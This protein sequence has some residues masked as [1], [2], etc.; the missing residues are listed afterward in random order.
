M[1][2][3]FNKR[4]QKICKEKNNRLCIGLD[5]D[6]NHFPHFRNKT[7]EAMEAFAKDVIDRTID[8]CPVYK[9]NFA[10]YERYGSKGYA[11]LER[12]VNFI[13]NRSLV[14]ADAKRGDIGNTSYQYSKSILDNMGCDAITVS[15]YM[16]KDAIE[17]FIENAEKGIFVLAITSNEGAAELQNNSDDKLPLYKKVIN[18]ANELNINDNIG[19]VVGATQTDVMEEI[20]NISTGLSWLI[21]GVGSQGGSLEKSITISNQ[22]NIGIINISRAI[23]YAGRGNLDDIIQSAKNYTTKIQKSLY[24]LE[25]C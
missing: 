24:S 25:T 20:K 13:N 21:P 8:F 16:G 15:P 5:I 6:P 12:I 2:L 10:F 23:L 3:S 9:P 1:K 17:P 11:L 19:I 4:L 18:I 14:I 7:I 22:G